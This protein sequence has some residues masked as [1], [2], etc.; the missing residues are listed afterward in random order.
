MTEPYDSADLDAI[1]ELERSRGYALLVER[2]NDELE[3]QRLE[4]ERP[5]T[6]WKTVDHA[7]GQ[8]RALRTVLAMTGTLKGE[9]KA[10]LDKE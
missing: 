5:T 7:Q 4:C 2:I 9:I 3:R 6:S 8:C 10:A 1:L